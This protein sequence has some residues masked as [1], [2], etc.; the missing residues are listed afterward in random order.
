[1]GMWVRAQGMRWAVLAAQAFLPYLLYIFVRRMYRRAKKEEFP[2]LHEGKNIRRYHKNRRLVGV[3]GTHFHLDYVLCL[4]DGFPDDDRFYFGFA[5]FQASGENSLRLF[6][7]FLANKK[8]FVAMETPIIGRHYF[9]DPATQAKGYFRVGLHGCITLHRSE[10][11]LPNKASDKRLKAILHKTRVSIKPYRRRGK[12]I[13][14]PLQVPCDQSL[15]GI[16]PF[17]AAQY[18]LINLKRYTSRPIVV[19]ANPLVIRRKHLMSH[20]QY[21]DYRDYFALRKLC[22]NLGITFYD[23]FK[24]EGTTSS[25]FLENCWCV[26]C[27]AS[28]FTMEAVLAGIP[29]IALSPANFVYPICSHDLS[30]IE[31]PKMPDRIPWLSRLAYC[32]W[33]LAEIE[34]GDVWRHFQPSIERLLEKR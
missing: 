7:E 17:Q 26:V 29:A 18:D 15:Q 13:L 30:E 4:R 20:M 16:H 32:Q 22:E 5:E 6:P 3:G 19:T 27:Q 11:N 24:K 34:N 33:T 2:L 25:V 12:H 23:D 1:M 9:N 28:S 14:Y 31:N 8:I 21:G 10:Y